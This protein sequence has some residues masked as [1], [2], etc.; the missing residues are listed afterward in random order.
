MGRL[1]EV[2]EPPSTVG[3]AKIHSLPL[4]RSTAMRR[5]NRKTQKAAEAME[6]SFPTSS[7]EATILRPLNYLQTERVKC[8]LNAIGS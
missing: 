8:G 7:V 2:G 5:R 3:Q 1:R 4:E 6:K